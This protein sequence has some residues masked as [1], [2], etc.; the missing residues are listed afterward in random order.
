MTGGSRRFA[1]RDRT[2]G[3]HAALDAAVGPLASEAA[4]RR[5]LRGLHCFRAPVERAIA[6]QRDAPPALAPLIA[7]DLAEIGLAAPEPPARFPAP[8]SASARAGV[9]YVLEGSALGARILYRQARALGRDPRHLAAQTADPRAW[10]AFCARLEQAEDFD[11]EAAA[12]AALETFAFARE[13]FAR[14]DAD[15]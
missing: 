1:L 6:G 11:L 7:A 3:A 4:Y 10:A 14:A 13:A 5:Y 2:A 15:D 8:G 12:A 9:A